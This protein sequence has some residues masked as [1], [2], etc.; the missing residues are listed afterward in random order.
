MKAILSL[1]NQENQSKLP[2]NKSNKQNLVS[3]SRLLR[4]K[5]NKQKNRSKKQVMLS[6]LKLKKKKLLLFKL[7]KKVN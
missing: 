7:I 2:I 4:N 1:I 6:R 5:F 3:P